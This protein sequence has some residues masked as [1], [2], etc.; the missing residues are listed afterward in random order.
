MD[1]YTG[2]VDM[3]CLN[4]GK[5]SEKLMGSLPVDSV[6]ALATSLT[7]T[8]HIPTRYIRPEVESE[9][10]IIPGSEHDDIPVIDY[11][12]LLDPELSD[13]ECSKLH[14]ACQNWGFF[15]VGKTSQ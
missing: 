5:G 1:Q 11:H 2:P 4:D 12:K 14:L 10:I 13:A 15:Q 7:P 9:A 6:R 3:V 8:D